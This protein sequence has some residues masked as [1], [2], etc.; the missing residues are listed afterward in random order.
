MWKCFTYRVSVCYVL[1]SCD[2]SACSITYVNSVNVQILLRSNQLTHVVE[3]ATWWYRLIGHQ[4]KISSVVLD[5]DF[6]SLVDRRRFVLSRGGSVFLEP[7]ADVE[8]S[9][10]HC[11]AVCAPHHKLIINDGMMLSS[12]AIK[13]FVSRILIDCLLSSLFLSH[14]QFFASM[15]STFT[16]NFFLSIY[17]NNPGDLSNPGLINFGRFESDVSTFLYIHILCIFSPL[18]C[19]LVS[20]KDIICCFFRLWPI[21]SM[22]FPCSSQWE[23]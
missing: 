5:S 4:L 20:I 12:T 17:H 18:F 16:L 3:D 22:R 8:D 11:L 15:I 9:K 10:S 13:R 7:D 6:V 2:I 19:L 23:L 14:L 1:P 21:T